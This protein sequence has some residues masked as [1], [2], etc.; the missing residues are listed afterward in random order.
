MLNFFHE[1]CCSASIVSRLLLDDKAIGNPSSLTFNRCRSFGA[2]Y[3]CVKG[4]HTFMFKW[5]C[6]VISFV[7]NNKPDASNILNLFCLKTLHVSGIS[8]AHHQEL[9]TVHSATGT[10]HAGYVTASKHGQVGT[11]FQPDS[12]R[13]CT[14]CR[15]YSRKLLMLGTEDARKM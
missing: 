9:S 2:L 10:F 11:P 4:K 7:Q 5:P 8:C 3:S 15:V 6:I 12:A 14:S 13:K 1:P